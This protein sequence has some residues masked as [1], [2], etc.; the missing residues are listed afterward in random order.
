MYLEQIYNTLTSIEKILRGIVLTVIST[1]TAFITILIFIQVI[2]R[3]VLL[4]SLSW[5]EELA[6]FCVVWVVFI[7]S[8]YALSIGAHSNMDIFVRLFPEKLRWVIEK[9]NALIILFFSGV[10]VRYGI[11][12]VILGAKQKSSALLIPMNYVYLA[13]PVGGLILLFYDLL[14]LL[15]KSR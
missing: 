3:Y 5:S 14:I 11:A 8:G 10:I 2:F 1:L 13:I 15:K 9:F 7:G 6:R 12:L 4:S